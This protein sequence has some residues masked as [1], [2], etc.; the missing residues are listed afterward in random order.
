MAPKRPRMSLEQISDMTNDLLDVVRTLHNDP[1]PRDFMVV[2]KG[3]VAGMLIAGLPTK[4]ARIRELSK[5]ALDVVRALGVDC[6][7]P[8]QPPRE[9]PLQ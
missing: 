4:E 8:H 5:F 1:D 7:D 3:L 9:G 6:P 2:L